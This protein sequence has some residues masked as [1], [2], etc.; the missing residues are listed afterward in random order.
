MAI[1][2][3]PASL[4]LA[5]V[6]QENGPEAAALRKGMHRVALYR[7]AHGKLRPDHDTAKI[8]EDLS[9]GRVRHSDWAK[10]P[11]DSAAE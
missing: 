1:V 6:L 4:A 7:Y 2:I 8:I 9:G 5:A 10:E 3:T 11:T